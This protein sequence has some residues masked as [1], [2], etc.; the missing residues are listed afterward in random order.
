MSRLSAIRAALPQGA[1]LPDDVWRRRHRWM[2]NLLW[3]H[4][5]ALPILGLFRHY[6]LFHTLGHAVPM[7]ACAVAATHF[8][9]RRREASVLVSL[10]LLTSSAELVHILN[11][12]TEAHFHFFVMISV[13]TLYEDW[14]P[15][16]VALGFVVLHHG[17]YGAIE[18]HGVYDHPG[19][20]FALAALHGAF[21]LAAGVANVIAWRLNEDV[22]G[23]LREAYDAT[24][25][26]LDTANE[27]YVGIDEEGTIVA[28]NLEAAELFGFS[29]EE[30]IGRRWTETIVPPHLVH[31][32]RDGLARLLAGGEGR[33]LEQRLELEAI[34]R[35]GRL[36]PIEL[37]VS[38]I[39]THTG[40]QINAFLHDIS[41]RKAFEAELHARASQ[42]AAIAQFGR[43]ALE[44]GAL[45][46]TMKAA[47]QL[48][49]RELGVEIAAILE[50]DPETDDF[51][52]RA[53]IQAEDPGARIPGGHASH[54][55][56]TLLAREPVV[57][58]DWSREMR[59]E[60]SVALR[61]A[62]ATGG[63]CVVIEGT[64][65]PYGVIGAQST[66]GRAFS[67]QDVSF[68]Q[69]VANTLAVALERWQ[70][71]EEIRHNA[72]HDPLTGLPNR[73]LYLDRLALALARARRN[74]SCTAVLF[75][76]LD[77]FK[78]VND[79]LGHAAGDELLRR[80]APRIAGALRANDTVAR[81]GG[82][83]LIVLCEDIDGEE[84]AI[85]VGERILESFNAGP[86]AV[87]EDE[88]FVTA[89][90]GVAIARSDSTP[91][92]L[93]RDADTAMYRAK[94][95]GAGRLELFDD[96]LRGRVLDRL[97]LESALRRAVE[98]RELT[99]AYQPIVA[100]GDRS[101]AHVEALLRWEH[102]ELGHVSPADFIPV[103]EETGL[104]VPL[105]RWVLEQAC[106]DAAEWQRHG[107]PA[108]VCVNISPR[109]LAQPDFAE[110]VREVLEETGLPPAGLGLEITETVLM[111]QGD[112]PLEVLGLVRALGVSVIL[113][114][115]GTGYS[116]L[117]YLQRLP[118]DTVKLDRSFIADLT[119]DGDESAAIVQAVVT[120]AHA[121][122][123][124]VVGEGVETPDQ[125][126]RLRRLGCAMAQGFW[127]A[128]PVP[129][130]QLSEALARFVRS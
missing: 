53:S 95:Q 106:R 94:E 21:V 19:N 78:M 41:D 98:G 10:G 11:G 62:G 85:I 14:L 8:A 2:L 93:V 97:R 91:G 32:H 56:A 59:F 46:E 107:E 87:F 101:V 39:H 92:A 24:R 74:G 77:G 86:F 115:F 127:F 65:G 121:L 47:V 110:M 80:V 44:R 76:D 25:L 31:E 75:V 122:E 71:E 50:H 99:L 37:T 60:Q 126:D 73:T 117:G 7:V 4:A 20:P 70:S 34:D 112:R 33:I 96:H 38:A 128:R 68:A 84:E 35:H 6:G 83:E 40:R 12:L 58:E 72:L 81:F 22:R 13:L 26:T 51:A 88:V 49:R 67:S 66:S 36:F 130:A 52:V 100:L 1:T 30:A 90:V 120:M 27:A 109:Q 116:S 125:A 55:G 129:M 42:Q 69:S 15:F 105:G 18:P 124:T 108:S 114:D 16:L 104:I 9:D 123:L 79:S 102:A 119:E 113:D 54:A 3:G 64:S 63:I 111:E 17:V 28:W 61:D 23:E 118:I 45:E 82:D 103:A 48:L 43:E 29:R 57:V 5:L 89:S